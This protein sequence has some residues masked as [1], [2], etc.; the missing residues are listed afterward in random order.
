MLSA[1]VRRPKVLSPHHTTA[2]QLDR[3]PSAVLDVIKREPLRPIIVI[4]HSRPEAVVVSYA[5]YKQLIGENDEN[6][7]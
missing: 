3:A 1:M 7:G 4:R 6:S 5:L 2:S